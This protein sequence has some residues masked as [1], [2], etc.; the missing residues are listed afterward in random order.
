[1]EDEVK[2][3][4]QEMRIVAV[5]HFNKGFTTAYAYPNLQT[6]KSIG[7]APDHHSFVMVHVELLTR[8]ARQRG[9]G[10]VIVTHDSRIMGIADRVL[11][12]ADGSLVSDKQV[13]RERSFSIRRGS[14]GQAVRRIPKWRRLI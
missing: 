11:H 1:M 8:L 14:S 4:G 2:L 13:G 10:V 5:T 7:G 3:N 9:S 12:L 6:L